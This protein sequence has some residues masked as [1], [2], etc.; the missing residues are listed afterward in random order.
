MPVCIA[1]TKAGTACRFNAREGSDKCGV[2]RAW[3]PPLGRCEAIMAAG[4]Q[5]TNKRHHADST[6]CWMHR[7]ST[8]TIQM[9]APAVVVQT[10]THAG[11]YGVG[12]GR[13][14]KQANAH[15]ECKMHARMRKQREASQRRIALYRR[16]LGLYRDQ[17][18]AAGFGGA[19]QNA[20]NALVN[21]YR[22]ATMGAFRTILHANRDAVD[23]TGDAIWA[24]FVANPVRPDDV[25][26]AEWEDRQRRRA[27]E[28]RQRGAAAPVGLLAEIAGSTQ[29][30]HTRAVVDQSK[31]GM[32][33]LLAVKVQSG[34]DDESKVLGELKELWPAEKMLPVHAD[35]RLWWDQPS[36]FEPEDHMYRRLLTG[37]WTYIKSQEDAEL[38]KELQK[39]MLEECREA[40]GKCCQ[41]HT[42]RLVNVLSG[43][44][45]GIE[46]Q[47]TKGEI[48]QQKFAAIS[49]IEDEEERY[50]RATQVLA[51]LGVGADE[52]GPWLDAIATA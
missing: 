29:N 21:E 48:L 46:V 32:D 17:R 5:C 39:R 36:C 14:V 15:N 41:G 31:R 44:V 7:N 49:N 33:F 38:R 1:V 6:T 4:S 3:Q 51:E 13:E 9:E 10:C 11:P 19:D 34:W 30:I 37:L 2:H 8:R 24:A 45:E 47:Q 16:V 23:V 18:M 40:K 35:I 22:N 50:V 25:V 12:C 27:A 43:F 20:Q 42:N 52:A 26:I 28:D